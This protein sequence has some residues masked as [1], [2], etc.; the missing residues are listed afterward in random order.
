[1][2]EGK[3]VYSTKMVNNTEV[4]YPSI[5]GQKAKFIYI[6]LGKMLLGVKDQDEE[7]T[8]SRLG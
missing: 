3:F 1:M 7:Q 4:V 2:D 5:F 6:M 8:I